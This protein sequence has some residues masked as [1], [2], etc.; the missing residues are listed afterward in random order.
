MTVGPQGFSIIDLPPSTPET[1]D[2]YDNLPVDPFMGNGTRHKRF[3]QY[4]LSPKPG[5][6]GGWIYE[7]LPHR[8]YI[9][10]TKYNNVAGGIRRPY[11]PVTVDF[12]PLVTVGAEALDLDRSHDWQINIHQNRSTASAERRAPITPEG[13][14][15]DGHEYIMIAVLRRHN[16]AGGETRL[17]MPDADA[18]FWT[19]TLEA[20]QA[21]LLDDAAVKHEATDVTSADGGPGHRDIVIVAYSTWANRWYGEE[22]EEAAL[23]DGTAN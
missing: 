12:T 21:V 11:E 17:W 23:T 14:H 20:G 16:V 1:L 8:D 10:Y 3:T 5:P 7:K 18:P 2:S 22:Y 9:T 4:R 6:D 19:G 13:V 15:S